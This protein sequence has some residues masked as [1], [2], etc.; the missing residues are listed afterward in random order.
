MF[1]SIN[2]DRYTMNETITKHVSFPLDDYNITNQ[3]NYYIYNNNRIPLFD[4]HWGKKLSNGY[5]TQQCKYAIMTILETC[6]KCSTQKQ[7]FNRFNFPENKTALR[8]GQIIGRYRRHITNNKIKNNNTKQLHL[9]VHIL[10]T[11]IITQI[12]SSIN[13]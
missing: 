13:Y 5:L 6:L 7:S 12:P 8:D 3:I 2:S 1:Y 10:Y 11:K 9:R 4:V